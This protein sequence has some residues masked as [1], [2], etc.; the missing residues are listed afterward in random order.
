MNKLELLIGLG[1]LLINKREL[2]NRKREL[3]INKRELQNRKR[4]LL[5]NKRELQNRIGLNLIKFCFLQI[6]KVDLKMQLVI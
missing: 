3:L 2:Q 1:E 5:I 4:E 6:N